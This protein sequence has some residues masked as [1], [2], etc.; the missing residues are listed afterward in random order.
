M[1]ESQPD[2]ELELNFTDIT[3][4]ETDGIYDEVKEKMESEFPFRN[5]WMVRSGLTITSR[6]GMGE[7]ILH[8][9]HDGNIYIIAYKPSMGDV[10]Y[11]PDIQGLSEWAQEN[12]WK[13]PQPHKDLIKSNKEFW[14]YFYDTLLLDS[15]YFDSIYGKRPQLEKEEEDKK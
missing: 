10:F 6:F 9:Y 3:L 13:I 15:D 11:N 4:S 1:N 5:D 12:G 7:M 8:F 14:R 2:L